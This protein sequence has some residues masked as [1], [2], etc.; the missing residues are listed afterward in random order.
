MR[1]VDRF[2]QNGIGVILD[3]VPGHFAVDDYGLRDYDGTCVYEY[4]FEDVKFNEWG[5]LSFNLGRNDVRSFLFSAAN[6]WIEK[7]HFDG[8]RID[9]VSNILYWQGK[10]E[11]GVN[12]NGVEFLRLMN[13]G[14]KERHPDILIAAEDSTEYPH[15]TKPSD[16][17]GLGFDYKWDMGWMHDTLEFFQMD[18]YFRGGCTNKLSFSMWYFGSEHFLLPLSHDEV[19][20]GKASILQKM[21]GAHE[22]KFPQAR[23]FYTYMYI[24]PGKKLNFMGNEIGQ[25]KEW[26]EKS[27][28]DWERLSYVEHQQFHNYIKALNHLYLNHPHLHYDYGYGNFDWADLNSTGRSIYSIRRRTEDSELLAVLHFDC[29]PSAPYDLELPP[30]TEVSL[31]LHSNQNCFGGSIDYPASVYEVITEQIQKSVS[32]GDGTMPLPVFEEQQ[33]LRIRM[34]PY[35]CLIFYVKYTEK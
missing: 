19:V 11:K 23:A 16:Q 31:I 14:L 30:C 24:H 4:P 10:R 22:T 27:E 26:S 32:S 34:N 29:E 9:S 1:M 28:E 12:N 21:N 6:Y 15:V 25:L 3:F 33:K 5:S 7:F 13:R 20:H 17:G 35:D 18:P 8:L 2:H